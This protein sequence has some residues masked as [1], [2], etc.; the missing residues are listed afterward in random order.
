[1]PAL[2][3][4]PWLQAADPAAHMARGMQIGVQLGAQRAAE[5]A[6]QQQAAE[7]AQ[8]FQQQMSA[9][10]AAQQFKMQ[11][12][13]RA[14]Q[15][16]AQEQAR[17]DAEL[18]LKSSMAADKSKAILQYQESVKGGMD[19]LQAILQYGPAMGG[20]AS[21]EAAALRS[22]ATHSLPAPQF[23]P[24]NVDSGEPA[25]YVESGAGGV[26]RVAFPPRSTAAATPTFVPES[27]ETGPA[28]WESGGRITQ[29]RA[30]QSLSAADRESLRANRKIIADFEK[31][32]GDP[33]MSRAMQKA[34]PKAYTEAQSE[35]RDAARS[36]LELQPDDP[37]AK[38]YSAGTK[39]ASSKT[40]VE[41]AKE[42]SAEH[43]EWTKAQVIK[44]VNDETK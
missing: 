12:A 21:P 25:H 43:P 24:G 8:E 2:E 44:A 22:Q 5:A 11:Q 37:M 34:D 7:R 6:K 41:R 39:G 26:K 18:Q 28:H 31:A 13:A 29:A 36:I 20:Q 27:P 19:P 10:Q 17:A 30:A 1:M 40:K 3:I 23:V 9:E 32:Y 42:I 15:M 16:Q 33:I 38:R 35:A 14:E 4:P